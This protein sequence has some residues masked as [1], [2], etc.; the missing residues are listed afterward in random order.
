MACRLP[1]VSCRRIRPS[2]A[3]RP[4]ILDLHLQGRV[5]AREVVGGGGNQRAVAQIAE[6]RGPNWVEQLASLRAFEQRVLLV[7]TT[8]FGPHTAAAGFAYYMIQLAVWPRRWSTFAT[9]S[10]D[11]K[12]ANRSYL[13]AQFLNHAFP[14]LGR[15][16]KE[17][18]DISRRFVTGTMPEGDSITIVT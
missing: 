11:D 10:D 3:A 6:R 16:F 8:C 17:P 2:G 5:D 4:Q 12:G 1:L 9:L 14:F 18:S 7:F 13:R 15:A